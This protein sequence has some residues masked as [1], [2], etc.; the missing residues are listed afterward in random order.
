MQGSIANVGALPS[1]GNTQGDAYLNQTDDSLWIYDGSGF[2]SGGSIQG[3]AGAQGPQGEAGADGLQGEPGADGK[4]GTSGI[5]GQNGT[6]PVGAAIAYKIKVNMLGGSI[7]G[8]T[9]ISNVWA[10]GNVE[11]YNTQS[12]WSVAGWNIDRSNNSL[13]V[14]HPLNTPVLM[15]STTAQN[16]SN[17][18]TLSITGKTASTMSIQNSTDN[19]FA[20]FNAI[21]GI[22]TGG[23]TAGAAYVIITF[24]VEQY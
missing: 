9:P 24:F 23:A 21:T 8:E 18:F 12:G 16:G 13:T 1:S 22:N 14:T 6:N 19:S 20:K 17:L 15:G 3:P 11:I 10:P 5:D 7:N 2:V 4:D